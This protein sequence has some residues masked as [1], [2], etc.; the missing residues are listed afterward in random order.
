MICKYVPY[1]VNQVK[2][3]NWALGD[4]LQA[5]LKYFDNYFHAGTA[6]HYFYMV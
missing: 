3:V 6:S 1:S 2:M 5:P 4:T